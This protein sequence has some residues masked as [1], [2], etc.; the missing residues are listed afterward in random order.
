MESTTFGDWVSTFTTSLSDLLSR[1][2]AF[3]PN[4]IGAALIILVGWLIGIALGAFVDRLLRTV[5]LQRVFEKAKIEQI[6]KNAEVKMDTSALLG[7]MVKWV[8]MIV[9]FISASDTLQLPQV[10]EF[11]NKILAYIPNVTAAIGILLVGAIVAHFIG[12]VVKATIKATK[13]GMADFAT[14][15]TRWSI[16]TF[17][18]LAA[19]YQLQV[20][21]GLIQTLFIGVVALIA[22]AGGL[23][24]GLGG[25]DAAK[26][27]VNRLKKQ[28]Q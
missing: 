12:N 23:A 9:A 15:V 22:I 27:L 14:L 25:Q 13:L 16:W 21:T 5:G 1:I 19:M 3:I 17:S 28:I 2:G 26:D 24:F 6:L 4:L 10:S 7:A 11:L 18:I 20:A 8:I